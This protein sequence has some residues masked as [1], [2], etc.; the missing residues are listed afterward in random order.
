M[1]KYIDVDILTKLEFYNYGH[2]LEILHDAC[3][4]ERRELQECLRRL[5]LALD[6]IKTAGGNES[7]I[8]KKIDDV[9]Y[10]FG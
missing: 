3:P 8:S 4:A 5:Q 7:P 2:A 6:D 1:Q 9:L 10:P